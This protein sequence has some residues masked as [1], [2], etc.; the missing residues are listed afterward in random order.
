[1]S[2]PVF[3]PMRLWTPNYF[4]ALAGGNGTNLLLTPA[5]HRAFDATNSTLRQYSNLAVRLFYSD[6]TVALD[7]IH[8]P[9]V[10]SDAPTIVRVDAV[11]SGST[12]TLSAQVV[13]DPA[14]AIHEVWVT[15]T[16]GTGGSGTWTSVDLQQCVSP[17]PTACG[18]TSDSQ[19]WKAQVLTATL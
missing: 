13:G 10:L 6:L 19:F 7:A 3:F 15:Y 4:S 18:T 17:L 14:A 11:P 9:A 2:S 12:T 8:A 16:S 5:Q 1:F